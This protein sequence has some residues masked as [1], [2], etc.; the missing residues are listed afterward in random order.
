MFIL[1]VLPFKRG[2][3]TEVGGHFLSRRGFDLQIVIVTLM[4]PWIVKVLQ[5]IPSGRELPIAGRAKGL[6]CSYVM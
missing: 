2:F 6:H 4:I 5:K 1:G 3:E